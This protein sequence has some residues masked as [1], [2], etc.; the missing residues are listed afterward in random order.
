MIKKL[1]INN[2]FGIKQLELDLQLKGLSRNKNFTVDDQVIQVPNGDKYPLI[3]SYLGRNSSGK[4]S[5]IKAINFANWFMKRKTFVDWMVFSTL[6]TRDN[7]KALKSNVMSSGSTDLM[8]MNTIHDWNNPAII[9]QNVISKLFDEVSYVGQPSFLISI[10]LEDET[11]GVIGSNEDIIFGYGTDSK[12]YKSL[13]NIISSINS[14]VF[15]ESVQLTS[16]RMSLTS[17]FDGF[18]GAN[19]QNSDKY[20]N[21]S[22]VFTAIYPFDISAMNAANYL[23]NNEIVIS[24]NINKIIGKMGESET[25]NMIRM[26]D[27][28]VQ[29]VLFDHG[30]AKVYYKSSPSIGA[31]VQKLSSGTRKMLSILAKMFETIDNGGVLLIDE[32]ENGLHQSLVRLLVQI[33]S[34]KNINNKNA[35][36]FIT[37]HNNQLFNEEL[38][39]TRNLLIDVKDEDGV[40][41]DFVKNSP[42]VKRTENIAAALN[43]KNYYNDFFW[44][45]DKDTSKSTLKDIDIALIID[46]LQK[47]AMKS[48]NNKDN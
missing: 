39:D 41:V 13:Y 15:T 14:N 26:F 2:L 32:I 46:G 11:F 28:N 24:Q 30:V 42:A 44:G 8:S 40:H 1:Q 18:F 5:L 47:A 22:N 37:T 34:D 3:P 17:H 29:L 20:N 36:L 35:Q 33:I 6:K 16:I 23:D 48:S 7:I 10:D 4:T 43:N 21:N 19:D 9:A 45:R 38:I 27:P 31:T 12:K 25:A